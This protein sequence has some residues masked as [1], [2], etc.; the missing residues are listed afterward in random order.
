MYKFVVLFLT[1]CI[2]VNIINSKI[3]EVTNTNS[4]GNGSL[5]NALD[6]SNKNLGADTIVFKLPKFDNNYDEKSNKWT[7]LLKDSLP[8]LTSGYIYIDGLSQNTFS[9]ISKETPSIIIK[10]ANNLEFAFGIFSPN[11]RISGLIIQGFKYGILIY[12]EYAKNNIISENI[13]GPFEVG[14]QNLANENGILIGGNSRSNVIENNVISGNKQNGIMIFS[15][16]NNKLVNNK[17]GTDISGIKSNPNLVGIS[18]SKSENN[19]IGPKNIIS[20]NKDIAVLL[21]GKNTRLNRIIGN[22]IGTDS[23]G[24]KILHNDK[25]IV[26]KS[27]AN[28]NQ[29]GGTQTH[30]RNIISG[31]LQ[32][33]IYIEAADSNVI[34]GNYIGTDITG[35]DKV[36][37]EDKSLMQGNGVEFNIVA[38]HNRLGGMSFNERNIISGNKVYGI[39]YYGNC[40]Y[41]PAINN[42]IGTDY[43]SI[44]PLPNATGICF[45]CSSNHNDVIKNVISGNI[46]YGLFFVTRGTYYNRMIGNMV[47]VDSSGTI[48]VPNDIGMVVSTGAA[49]NIIGGEKTEDRNIF[50]GNKLSGLMITNTLTEYNIVKG[51]NFGTDITGTKK[52]PNLYGIMLSSFPKHNTIDNNLISGNLMTG[53]I[54]NEQADSNLII[55]NLIGTDITSKHNLGNGSVGI[56]IDNASCSNIIGTNTTGNVIAYNNG[57]GIL[58]QHNRTKYNRISGN[59]IY[60]NN[61]LGIDIFPY[62][63]NKN[64]YKD[65]DD[66]TQSMLNYPIIELCSYD[67]FS[68]YLTIQGT[69]D[70]SYPELSIIE[71]FESYKGSKNSYAQGKKFLGIAIPNPEGKWKTIISN[72]L[73]IDQIVAVTIDKFGN[74]SEF[75]EPI[76]IITGLDE[77]IPFNLDLVFYPNPS[78]DKLH[79]KNLNNTLKDCIISIYTTRGELVSKKE[80][81]NE[82][83]DLIIIEL[84]D[85]NGI[86]LPNGEYLLCIYDIQKTLTF[87]KPIIIR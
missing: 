46:S 50:S 80:F 1:L 65:T 82:E 36:A 73:K 25:G 53:I 34:I 13:I 75:S 9:G 59:S 26:I 5:N 66:G 12:T 74:T 85:S 15:S 24:K 23:S 72:E 20:G 84:K 8:Y 17:I 47:G 7:I 14:N 56:Y 2:N 77:T 55:N 4:A 44:N 51:N 30:D 18:I 87:C 40:S 41:N 57:A 63:P 22:L 67:N 86:K 43:T 32:I 64:D 10:N 48:A 3:F 76:S 81:K 31:N 79:I 61:G 68:Q 37:S 83:T 62:G 19:E 58:L 60:E 38:K 78:V 52:I 42:F 27:L 45:D 29:I 54:L 69:V 6:L 35:T 21:V 28:S 39:V 33:G 16:N 49:Y 71:F 70:C 11:N